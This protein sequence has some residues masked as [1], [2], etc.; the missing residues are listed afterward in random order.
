MSYCSELKKNLKESSMKKKC[1]RRSF[2]YGEQLFSVDNKSEENI[3][4]ESF[5]YC[6]GEDRD[7]VK[8]S[9]FKCASCKTNFVRGVFFANG[10]VSDPC[11]SFHFEIKLK[12]KEQADVLYDFFSQNGIEMKYINRKNGV[13]LY[14]KKGDD[15]QDIM[16]FMGAT[17]EAFEFANEKIK[18]DFSNMA[19]RRNNFDYVNIQKTVAASSETV[20][21]IKLL[22]KRGKINELP[23]SLKETAMI[24]LEN[25]Y[26]N[27]EELASLHENRI[28]KSGVNHRLK[29]LIELAD[30]E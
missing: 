26:A 28:T 15:I 2:F 10:T 16:H 13:S 5:G 4:W 7:G 29:K 14:L 12:K 20:D 25:P 21:A 17:K 22:I 23:D 27:L 18:R 11:K 6:D 8:F 30:M 9:N 3:D 19:N 1:C 24:R